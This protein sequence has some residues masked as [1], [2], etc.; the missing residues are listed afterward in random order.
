M[1]RLRKRYKT[2]LRERIAAT[3]DEPDEAAINDEIRDL[4]IALAN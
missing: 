2:I 3:L 1:Q 4:F